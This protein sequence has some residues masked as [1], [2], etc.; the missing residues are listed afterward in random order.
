MDVNANQGQ[1]LQAVIG[2]PRMKTS[3]GFIIVQDP[4]LS[5]VS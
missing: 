4:R 5:S 1:K 3:L 2:D